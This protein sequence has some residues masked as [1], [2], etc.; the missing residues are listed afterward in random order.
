MKGRLEVM[1]AY[2]RV[3]DAGSFSAAARELGVAQPTISK[4]VA[5]LEA[6][7]GAQLLNRTSRQLNPTEAGQDYYEAVCR[8]LDDLDAAEQR[9]GRRHAAPAGLLRTTLPAAFGRMHVIPMLPAFL[10]RYPDIS[11]EV[12]IADRY[13]DLVEDGIDLAVRIGHLGDSSLIAK[14]IGMSARR[15]FASMAYLSRRQPPQTPADLIAHDRIVFAFQGAPQPWRF[16]RPGGESFEVTTPARIR[17]NDAEAVRAAVMQGLG[18]AQ[19]PIWLFQ[20]EIA[21]G[22]VA[23]VLDAWRPDAEP[24]QAVYPQ[25]RQA[26]SKVRVFID[27]LTKHLARS[28]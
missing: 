21:T 28:L 5:A 26:P 27:F 24:V 9:I 11:V 16:R 22:E 19:A 14:P 6:H 4:Q 20:S 2:R 13:L 25:A 18:V 7:L 17:A 10:A 12:V 15:T 23:L 8:L 1:R 3:V